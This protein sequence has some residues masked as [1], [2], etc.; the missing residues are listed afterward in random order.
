[1]AKSTYLEMYP[2][3]RYNVVGGHNVMTTWNLSF[4]EVAETHPQAAI[5]LLLISL[6][7][8]DDIPLSI[9]KSC[10]GGQY[11]WSPGG[12]FVGVPEGQG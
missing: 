4:N 6:L 9:L 7:E 5:L 12:D 1:M 8:A 3:T 11:Y 2:S 10:V